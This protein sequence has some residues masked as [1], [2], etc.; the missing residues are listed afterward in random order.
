MPARR[1]ARAARVVAAVAATLLLGALPSSPAFAADR[2][3][4]GP[5]PSTIQPYQRTRTLDLYRSGAMVT[6]F[7]SYWCVPAATQSMINLVLG[8]SDRSY[9]TQSR[10]YRELRASNL[11]RYTTRGNDVRGWAHVLSAHLGPGRTYGDQSF[12]TQAAAYNA[13]VDSM[14]KTRRPVGIVVDHGTHAWTVV[15]FRVKETVGVRG[16]RS[17]LGFYVVGPLGSPRD[18]WP[19]AFYTVAQLSARFSRYHESTRSVIWEGKF[20]IV[21]P[22]EATGA[23][24]TSR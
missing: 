23:V 17:I 7:T 2:N 19:K 6:Q 18:P 15:G 1:P 3:L 12:T 13:I 21:Q 4:G 9:A 5:S 8:T 10:L 24:T 11:Y 16:S 14:T 22:L 20:V